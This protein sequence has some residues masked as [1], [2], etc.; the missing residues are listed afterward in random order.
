MEAMVS[1]V[2]LQG[3]DFSL[4]LSLRRRVLH[5]WASS[6][7]VEKWHRRGW[8]SWWDVVAR[9]IARSNLK[10]FLETIDRNKFEVTFFLQLIILID[11]FRKL[12]NDQQTSVDI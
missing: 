3:W 8:L 12:S 11:F 9:K 10:V 7:V 4:Q 2:V 1:L 5:I 6:H